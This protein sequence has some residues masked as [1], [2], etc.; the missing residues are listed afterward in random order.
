MEINPRRTSRAQ[1]NF[2]KGL[3]V[4]QIKL[5]VRDVDATVQRAIGRIHSLELLED[6]ISIAHGVELRVY[7]YGL[8]HRP[9]RADGGVLRAKH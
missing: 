4:G 3:G 5:E 1:L 2:L 9:A 6:V 8:S 7:Q